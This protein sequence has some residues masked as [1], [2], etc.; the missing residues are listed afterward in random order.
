MN[1]LW[2]LIFAGRTEFEADYIV[3]EDPRPGKNSHHAQN[4]KA[5]VLAGRGEFRDR[6]NSAV[7]QVP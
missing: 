4:M 7:F 5:A 3:R 2:R 6:K 1:S